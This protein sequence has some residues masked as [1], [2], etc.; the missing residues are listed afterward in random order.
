MDAL[1]YDSSLFSMFEH[2]YP[3]PV[4]DSILLSFPHDFQFENRYLRIH[5][6]N[7]DAMASKRIQGAFAC[8][9]PD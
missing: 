7:I 9:D 8:Y 5:S 1:D 6:G 4:C 2:I 3:G